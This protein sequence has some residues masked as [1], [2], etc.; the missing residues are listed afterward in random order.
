MSVTGNV[1]GETLRGKMNR[2]YELRGYSAYEVAVINGF[3]GTVGEW[4]ESLRGEPGAVDFESLTEDQIAMLKG[5]AFTYEDFTEEQL[6]ELK[7]EQGEQGEQG[8]DYVLTA[9]D[10]TE[11]ANI[12]LAA[13]PT[14]TGGNY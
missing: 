8:E 4:L 12:V 13:L 7:G 2:L 14:W 6:A 10:K 9:T 11:I 5:D 1:T 3:V